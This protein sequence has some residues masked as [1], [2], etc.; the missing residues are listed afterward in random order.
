[1]NINNLIQSGACIVQ[2][3]AADLKDF[4]IDILDQYAQR[5]AKPQEETL[6]TTAQASRYL[7][8]DRSTL[9]RWNRE[10]YLKPM[11]IGNRYRY[12]LSDLESIRSY[13]R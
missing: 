10:N 4:A 13:R 3:S 8:V 11:M 5:Q 7:N 12:R 9:W 2:V 1:M 6:L